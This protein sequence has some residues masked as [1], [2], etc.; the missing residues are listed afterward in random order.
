MLELI[1]KHDETGYETH[2]NSI[3]LVIPCIGLQ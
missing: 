2:P 1:F 3:H